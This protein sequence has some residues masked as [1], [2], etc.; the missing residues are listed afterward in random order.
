[1]AQPFRHKTTGIFQL[2]RKVPTELRAVL[3]FEYK[4]TLGTRDPAEAKAKFAA[5]WSQSEDAFRLARA[6]ASGIETLNARDIQQL[7]ARWFRAQA[8]ALDQTGNAAE[9]LVEGPKSGYERPDGLDMHASLLTLR[10]ALE[11][12]PEWDI[13]QLLDESIRRTLKAAGIPMPR[14]PSTL[15]HLRAAF[16]THWLKL[17]DLAAQRHEGDWL[18]SVDVL[19]DQPLSF[20]AQRVDAKGKTGLLDL[21]KT[22]KEDKVLTDGDTRAVRKTVA[23]YHATV[24]QFVELCGDGSIQSI[25]RATIREYR[26]LLAQLPAKGYGI[27]KLGA[28]ALIAKADA[29][30]LPR[31]SE[32]TIRNKLKAL[33][34]VL[35]HG[36]RLG[37]TTENPVIAGGIAKDAAKAATKRSAKTRQRKDY[38]KEELASIFTSPIYSTSGWSAPRADFGKAWYWMPLLMYYTGARREELAQLWTTDVVRPGAEVPYLSIL[39]TDDESDGERGVKTK[40]SRRLIPLHP[41]LIKLG[42]IEYVESLPDGNAQLFPKLKANP[43]G[44][45]G[46]NFGKR[47]AEYLREVVGLRSSATPSHGFRHAFKTLCREVGIAEDVHDAIT[48]H[49]SGA[50]ARTYGAMP[51]ARMA[52]ELQ[53]LPPAPGLVPILQSR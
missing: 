34:T 25:N 27:R 49:S 52:A 19:P 23:A 7:A 12:D 18:S 42:F 47:W 13:T 26:K 43:S 14:Q 11:N 28:K 20:E 5:A 1:M 39:A 40:G 48:G 15:D 35:S 46:A 10:E 21:F 9:W 2:R 45:F 3:G 29:E 50:V 17:S 4:R 30:G 36:V 33:S 53:K 24:V 44:Y 32:P 22:Y 38:T 31:I 16:R 51:L 41:D 37:L 8:Q 6:Q